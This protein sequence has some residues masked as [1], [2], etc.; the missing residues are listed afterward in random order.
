MCS[1]MLCILEAMINYFHTFYFVCNKLLLIAHL[2]KIKIKVYTKKLE[3]V[4]GFTAIA[5]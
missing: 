1:H 4:I 5:T 3:G 2:N